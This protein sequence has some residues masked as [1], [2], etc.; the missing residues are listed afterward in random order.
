MLDR[1]LCRVASIFPEILTIEKAI[2][3]CSRIQSATTAK[4]DRGAQF[5]PPTLPGSSG[6]ARFRLVVGTRQNYFEKLDS[7]LYI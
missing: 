1:K 6:L 3:H 7:L 4:I 5:T 2:R